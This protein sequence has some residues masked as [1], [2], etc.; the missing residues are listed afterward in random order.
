MKIVYLDVGGTLYK[1]SRDTLERHKGSMLAT[2][3]SN[4]WKEGTTNEPIFID[5]NGRLFE[6]VLDY[7][8][9][10]KLYL[11][12]TVN[13][14]AM[15]DEFVYYGVDVDMSNVIESH[16]RAEPRLIN[17][18][19]L[20]ERVDLAIRSINRIEAKLLQVDLSHLTSRVYFNILFM[21]LARSALF[22][23]LKAIVKACK[24][25]G[26]TVS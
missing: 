19:H 8:R 20:V 5:R 26:V 25:Q 9:A 13:L 22:V 24:N 23:G 4:Q 21:E 2:L 11:P 3:V 17:H 12:A 1:V 6:Y 16:Y 10:N 15:M 14:N 18:P 7:L